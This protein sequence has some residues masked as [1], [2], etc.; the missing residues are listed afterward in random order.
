MNSL[1]N[2]ADDD[3]TGHGGR[4]LLVVHLVCV[5]FACHGVF[6]VNASGVKVMGDLI[7]V[8]SE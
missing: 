3:E 2:T 6:H 5:F 1:R 8:A 7:Y 4:L